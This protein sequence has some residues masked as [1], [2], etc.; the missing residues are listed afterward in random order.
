[1]I[2]GAGDQFFLPDS[3][4][5]YFDELKGEK[6]LRYVPNADH[7]LRGS[8][9]MEGITAFQ[10]MVIAG[11]ARPVYS[12]TLEKDGAIRVKSETPPKQ[13]LVWQAT[14]PK[15]RDFRLE[16]IG[17]AYSSAELKP[18]AD[19]SYVARVRAPEQ[20]WTAFFA[21]LTFDSG[22]PYPLKV[23]TAV[24]V[25]P[26]KLPF[27]GADLKKLPYEGDLA[28]PASRAKPEGND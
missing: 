4:R 3:S 18:E 8:D 28:R 15:A 1:M 19:G 17:K 7:S 27:A 9:A 26:D 22:G 14:N 24:R 2:Q 10:Q 25:L 5:F 20:G 12:W 13:V 16:T 11:R 21:E 6:Y 23:T